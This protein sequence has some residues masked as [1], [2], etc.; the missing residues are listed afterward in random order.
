ME[1]Y[2]NIVGFGSSFE[3][4]FPES[5]KYEDDSLKKAILHAT[6]NNLEVESVKGGL[7]EHM[8]YNY[9]FSSSTSE[10]RRNRTFAAIE[11]SI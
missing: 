10:S 1:C 7:D 5:V 8:Y 9:I 4:L 3:F 6:G 11:R 2:F